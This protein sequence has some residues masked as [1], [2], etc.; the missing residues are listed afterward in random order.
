MAVALIAMAAG[1]AHGALMETFDT[2]LNGSTII[3]QGAWV[4]WEQVGTADANVTNAEA[5]SDPHSLVMGGATEI[6]LVPQFTGATSGLW[7]VDV[8]TYVPGAADTGTADVGF[9]A[10]HKGFLG[11]TDTQWFGAISL[12]MQ[13]G[14]VNNNVVIIRDQWILAEANFDIDAQTYDILYNGA[15]ADSGS[16]TGSDS[17]LVGFDFFT[18][19]DASTMYFD[20]LSVIPEPASLSLLGLAGIC[21]LRR[22]RT[23]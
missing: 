15:L 6:D 10:R 3:G 8:M 1:G 14:M 4:G 9:L 17:A 22:R 23:R 2:Y 5:F 21:L 16:F 12:N 19:A 13:S 20:N 18:P 11:A 7:N